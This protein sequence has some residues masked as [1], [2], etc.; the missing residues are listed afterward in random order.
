MGRKFLVINLLIL[1]GVILLSRYLTSEWRSFE[2]QNNVQRVLDQA[3]KTAGPAPNLESTPQPDSPQPYPDFAVIP[4]KDLFM[5]ERRPPSPEAAK[6]EV[7]APEFPKPPALNGVL[8]Q[9]GK[10][11]VLVSIFDTPNAKGQSRT[12][13]VGDVINGWTIAEIKET[14][15]VL[16]WNDQEKVIDMFDSAPQQGP[17]A[18]QTMA[19]QAPT[20]IT[21]G[22]SVSAVETVEASAA[23]GGSDEKPGLVIGVAGGQGTNVGQRGGVGGQGAM[24]GSRGVGGSRSMGGASTRSGRTGQGGSGVIGMPGGGSSVPFNSGVRRGSQYGNQY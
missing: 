14:S 2:A 6:E 13:S 22:S 23:A 9:D 10:T 1:A 15:F 11:Q 21:I 5:A 17:A 7:K 18:P 4:E 8:N 20:V 16:R 12:M 24:G 3:T 19:R